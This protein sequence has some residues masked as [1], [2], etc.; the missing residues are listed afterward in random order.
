MPPGCRRG[1]ALCFR[2]V[3]TSFGAL[4][5]GR[6]LDKA[7]GLLADFFVSEHR[8]AVA[9]TRADAPFDGAAGSFKPRT[10]SVVRFNN[11]VPVAAPSDCGFA[12]LGAWFGVFP[13]WV[14]QGAARV[15]R[16]SGLDLG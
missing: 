3:V 8:S 5:V 7:L 11:S 1:V 6:C 13:A 12:R 9:R 15:Y 4:T 10:H 14:C 2:P 16:Y